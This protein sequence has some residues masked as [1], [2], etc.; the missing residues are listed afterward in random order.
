[1]RSSFGRFHHF[2]QSGGEFRGSELVQVIRIGK[3]FVEEFVISPVVNV[4]K[5]DP[6]V[7]LG[8]RLKTR[9]QLTVVGMTRSVE[10]RSGGFLNQ[11]MVGRGRQQQLNAVIGDCV[12]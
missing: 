12:D 1:M 3:I 6:V 2:H 8:Q 10:I 4:Q 5:G 9:H 7:C 11:R